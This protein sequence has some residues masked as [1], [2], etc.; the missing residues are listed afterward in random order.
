MFLTL[1]MKSLLSINQKSFSKCTL[2]I[3]LVAFISLA[4]YGSDLYLFQISLRSSSSSW[5]R[6]CTIFFLAFMID[7]MVSV[8]ASGNQ[9][10]ASA[11]TF[12]SPGR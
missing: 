9:E 6:E 1:G 2:D 10:S 5:K 11:T 8:P 4:V 7:A 3:P 12:F